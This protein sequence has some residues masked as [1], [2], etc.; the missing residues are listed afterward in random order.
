M[1]VRPAAQTLVLKAEF[2]AVGGSPLGLHAFSLF[3]H[4]LAAI[5]AYGL[6]RWVLGNWKWALL[7]AVLFA[8]GP[9]S[10]LAVSW[11]AAQDTLVST[12]LLVAAVYAYARASFDAQRS[13]ATLR[14]GR[15]LLALVL[16]LPLTEPSTGI[17]A[18]PPLFPRVDAP[19]TAE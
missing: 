9:N 16:W 3:W 12:F 19:V 11:T 7:A 6:C 4:W 5:A 14:T 15:W 1:A 18:A 13:P 17:E 8:L 10:T 2:L